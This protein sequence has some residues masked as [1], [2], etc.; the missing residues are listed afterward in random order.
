MFNYI[1]TLKPYRKILDYNFKT[2][3]FLTL[4]FQKYYIFNGTLRHSHF[5]S[6]KPYKLNYVIINVILFPNVKHFL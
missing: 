2:I 3:S 5:F 6:T 1:K 4:N